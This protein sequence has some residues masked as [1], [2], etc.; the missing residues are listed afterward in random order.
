MQADKV[1][2]PMA[3]PLVKGNLVRWRN[4]DDEIGV[5][6]VVEGG[7]VGVLF[8][9]GNKQ[10]FPADTDALEH[11]VFAKGTSVEIRTTGDRGTVTD[12][13]TRGGRY[14]YTVALASDGQSHVLEDSVRPAPPAQEA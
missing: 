13:G 11:L 9:S 2:E 4:G 3:H 14:A 10:I 1:Q 6:H 12:S 7:R 8:D 5:V